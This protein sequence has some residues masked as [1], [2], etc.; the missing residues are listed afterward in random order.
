MTGLQKF[1]MGLG[2][3]VGFVLL[4]LSIAVMGF[5]R[6]VSRA[7]EEM[8]EVLAAA[9]A[10]GEPVTASETEAALPRVPRSEN[11]A[12]SSRI[13][14]GRGVGRVW[15]PAYLAHRLKAGMAPQMG[16]GAT[17]LSRGAFGC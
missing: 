12:R 9:R 16:R 14:A 6:Q 5:A 8:A 15:N 2:V 10:A 17:A 3:F 7:Q 13:E 11:G 1:L 4:V